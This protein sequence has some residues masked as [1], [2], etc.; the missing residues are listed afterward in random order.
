MQAVK[1]FQCIHKYG[2]HIP[3]FERKYDIDKKE[4]SF[5][6]L[7]NLLL[8][9]GYAATYI[10]KPVLD[11]K[12]ELVFFTLWDYERLQF[13]WAEEQ[14][15]STKDL[16]EIKMA[17]IEAFQPD[18]FYNH[19]PRYD[20]NF[21]NRLNGYKNLKKICWDAIITKYP[22]L[23]ERYDYRLTLFEPFIDYWR[24]KGLKTHRLSPAYWSGWENHN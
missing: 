16:D 3:Y 1:V 24:N 10:L 15:L 14:G 7:R 4:L 8:Q 23:H 19:S 20:G 11:G 5:L 2:P 22:Y 6:E 18:V 17:Q 13:K 21:I 12:H 9:D